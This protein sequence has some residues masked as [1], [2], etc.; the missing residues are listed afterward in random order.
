MLRKRYSPGRI[1]GTATELVAGR[2]QTQTCFGTYVDDVP[3]QRFRLRVAVVEH[4]D[5][6]GMHSHEY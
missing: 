1:L 4:T 2:P 6:F 5:A 3:D